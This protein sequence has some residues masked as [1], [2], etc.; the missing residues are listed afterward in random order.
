M[1]YKQEEGKEEEEDK[2]DRRGGCRGA[3]ARGHT[4]KR[5][6]CIGLSDAQLSLSFVFAA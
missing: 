1:G 5:C 6:V 2:G 4:N 3:G